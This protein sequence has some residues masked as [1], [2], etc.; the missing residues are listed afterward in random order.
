MRILL[1]SNFFPPV[2][3]TACNRIVS[4][5][6]NWADAGHSVTILTT[7]KTPAADGRLG[8]PLHL[9]KPFPLLEI[10][11]LAAAEDHGVVANTAEEGRGL[12]GKVRRLAPALIDRRLKWFLAA[13]RRRREILRENFDI[14]V[15]SHPVVYAL[16]LAADFGR[17][18]KTPFVLDYRDLWTAD[19][20]SY[21]S[22][23]PVRLAETLLERRMVKRAAAVV[24][25][26]PGQAAMMDARFG[27]HADVIENGYEEE[28]IA[29]A[30]ALRGA[31]SRRSGGRI[32]IG[33][34]GRFFRPHRDPTP[35]F[36]AL[37]ELNREGRASHLEVCFFG[38]SHDEAQGLIEKFG[39][40]AIVQSV[41]TVSVQES[42]KEQALCD[43]LLF[44][45]WNDRDLKGVMTGKLYEYAAIG[46][47]ILHIGG[48][49][50]SD[51]A[52][53]IEALGIGRCFYHDVPALREFLAGF[54]NP[55]DFE[56]NPTAGMERYSRR[57]LALK[58]LSLLEKCAG[59][60]RLIR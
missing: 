45:D 25:V 5:L 18:S 35:F 28:L 8:S 59:A 6:R 24:T 29:P 40:G 22:I 50:G 32:R 53:F 38:G 23:A 15:G 48:Y 41:P 37:S 21:R 56:V 36:Q 52:R 58:Y 51:A 43:A 7:E 20:S 54:K 46:V 12:R 16:L 60:P 30:L 49:P 47:P 14:I 13:R 1:I 55:D 33:Y 34:F 42:M 44:L 10:P 27:I 31:R 57:N 19:T 4:F 17:F 9:D 3:N 26:S 11:Y 2:Q 39:I